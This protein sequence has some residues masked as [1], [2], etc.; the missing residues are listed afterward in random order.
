MLP[1]LS[2]V[3]KIKEKIWLKWGTEQQLLNAVKT[4]VDGDT[5]VCIGVK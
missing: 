3:K 4:L 1:V 2:P 5:V